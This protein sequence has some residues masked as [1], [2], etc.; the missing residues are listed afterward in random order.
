MTAAEDKSGLGESCFEYS[1]L[2]L[3]GA[4]ALA[5]YIV[6]RWGLLFGLPGDLQRRAA[7]RLEISQKK[8]SYQP[9]PSRDSSHAAE[10]A[11]GGTISSASGTR[12]AHHAGGVGH[13]HRVPGHV[14]KLIP[15]S[16]PLGPS[17]YGVP[18]H[19]PFPTSPV[20]SPRSVT[21]RVRIAS[22]PAMSKG[23]CYRGPMAM[24]RATSVPVS[25]CQTEQKRTLLPPGV[26]IGPL[27]LIGTRRGPRSHACGWRRAKEC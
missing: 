10:G 22:L 17:G 8:P 24:N 26:S 13:S 19:R 16:L 15:S 21:S 7:A 12:R 9:W 18:L 4:V 20:R 25:T 14:E 11:N 3:V 1:A 6:T 27:N 2:L 5:G 23:M